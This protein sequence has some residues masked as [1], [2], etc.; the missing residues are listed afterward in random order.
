M[1]IFCPSVAGPS[2][3]AGALAPG[4]SFFGAS[5]R[6]EFCAAGEAWQAISQAGPPRPQSKTR[7]ARAGT[8]GIPNRS[9]PVK[10]VSLLRTSGGRYASAVAQMQPGRLASLPCV[11]L[12]SVYAAP[13]TSP[14]LPL[15]L[16]CISPV[17]RSGF[18]AACVQ[19]GVPDIRVS[20][21]VSSARPDTSGPLSPPAPPESASK[22]D[23]LQ[24]LHEAY[25]RLVSVAK[26]RPLVKVSVV[27]TDTG[28]LASWSAAGAASEGRTAAKTTVAPACTLAANPPR[29]TCPSRNG[30]AVRRRE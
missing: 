29:D 27:R 7:I 26:A 4:A 5:I 18:L 22:L 11:W 12:C 19:P 15:Y 10:S 16:P 23:A 6:S 2:S 28:S 1:K 24:T 13:C 9:K 14:L 17:L 3:S 25:C 21:S 20:R 30:D 8:N